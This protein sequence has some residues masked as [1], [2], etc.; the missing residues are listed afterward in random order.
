M[1][2]HLVVGQWKDEKPN[3][4]PEPLRFSK[5]HVG[6]IVQLDNEY[7]RI[8]EDGRRGLR[9]WFVTADVIEAQ[10]VDTN[11]MKIRHGLRAQFGKQLQAV[12]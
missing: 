9:S 4:Y 11:E 6:D 1:T 8:Y 3:L 12:Q 7:V 5:L 2:T 10:K